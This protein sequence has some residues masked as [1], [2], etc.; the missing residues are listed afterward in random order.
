MKQNPISS[1][2]PSVAF[3]IDDQ[4]IFNKHDDLQN[5]VGFV[6]HIQHIGKQ[7]KEKNSMRL[8]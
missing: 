5:T 4:I 8:S 3:L 7:K 1:R 6:E 2:L